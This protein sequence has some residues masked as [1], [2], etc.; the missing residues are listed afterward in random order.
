MDQVTTPT[1]SDEHCICDLCGKRLKSIRTLKSHKRVVHAIG[2]APQFRCEVCFKR[3]FQESRLKA[4]I[5]KA[6]IKQPLYKCKDCGKVFKSPENLSTSRHTCV[7]QQIFKCSW[8]E[9][10]KEFR[11][12]TYLKEHERTH[13]FPE[14]K[15]KCLKCFK[16]FKFRMQLFRHKK[17]CC[18]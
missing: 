9:C 17:N 1:T 2:K 15:Y 4:H 7:E 18:N 8:Q 10:D 12:K 13:V 16:K 6:H 3:Y 11:R 5:N 14:G